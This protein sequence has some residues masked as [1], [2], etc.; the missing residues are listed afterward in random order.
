[1]SIQRI[2]KII[3][4]IETVEMMYEQDLKKI[5]SFLSYM[6]SNY[7][8]AMKLLGYV[9]INKTQAQCS[10]SNVYE[11]KII[12][13]PKYYDE[14]YRK[15]SLK[16]H[17]DKGGTDE[18]MKELNQIREN[19]DISSLL[20]YAKKYKIKIDNSDQIIEDLN[21]ELKDKIENYVMKI[22]QRLPSHKSDLK[23]LR[24]FHKDENKKFIAENYLCEKGINIDK[25]EA[26][27][28]HI[29]VKLV[30]KKDLDVIVNLTLNYLFL[31]R[32]VKIS[33]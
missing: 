9:Y 12:K 18:K 14:I 32:S 24:D 11:E 31:Y 8:E 26:E 21:L 4:S 20:K 6:M 30:V 33:C 16:F 5:D 7:P 22:Y 27:E 25:G 1:M 23:L 10:L 3:N 15:L 13:L 17:S 19:G 2:N 28:S 29:C